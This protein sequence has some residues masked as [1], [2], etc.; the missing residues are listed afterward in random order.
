MQ[1]R[2]LSMDRLKLVGLTGLM[3]NNVRNTN[4]AGSNEGTVLLVGGTGK[5]GRRAAARLRTM[6]VPV[7]IASRSGNPPFDWHN[8]DGWDTVLSGARA[9]YLALPEEE[10]PAEMFMT[11]AVSSGVRRI[12]AL[13]GRSADTWGSEFWAGV[14]SF[15]RAVRDS[16]AAWSIMRPNNFNQNFDEY[17]FRPA[18]LA[19]ELALPL[20]GVPEPFIDA[21]DIAEVAAALLTEDG[22]DGQIYEMS[23]PQA[24]TFGEAVDIIGRA[25][26][27]KVRYRDVTEEEYLDLLR[28]DGTDPVEAKTLAAMFSVMRRGDLRSPASGVREVLGRE[29]LDFTTYAVRAAAAGA[30]G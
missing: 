2:L 5:V 18:I 15:E 12:V 22:H 26:G 19:G 7:R 25:S 3:A 30:W 1:S 29:P 8:P 23:G 16:G 14:V 28:R 4:P 24:L 20:D 11:Q 21:E 13:S 10:V 17:T 27:R 6:H 9:L